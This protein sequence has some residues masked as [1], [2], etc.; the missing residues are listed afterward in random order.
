MWKSFTVLTA[1]ILAVIFIIIVFSGNERV[2]TDAVNKFNSILEKNITIRVLEND[3]AIEQGYLAELMKAFNKKYK[4]YGITVVD[5]NMDQYLD[6]EKDGPYGYGP[7]ILYQANDMLMKYVE[8]KHILPLPIEELDCYNYISEKAWNAYKTTYDNID[9]YF[10]TPTNIQSSLLYYRK[11]LLPENWKTEW[12]DNNNEIPDMVESWTEL[13]KYSKQ[14]I[15]D[16][17]RTKYGY[18]KSLFDVYFSAGYLFSYG[19]YIFGNNSSDC[20]DIGFSKGE[21]EKGGY[22][23]RQLASLMN[24]ECIDDTITRN[25]YSKMAQGIYFAT[26]TTPDVYGLFIKEMVIQYQNQ[27]YT[28]D[29]ATTLAKEN[30]IAIDIPVLPVSGDL[31]DSSS[32]FISCKMMGGIQGYSISSYTEAPNACLAFINF[33]TSYEMMM[34]RNNLLGIVPARTDAATA[35]GGLAKIINNNLEN[36]NIVVMPSIREVAQIWKP[37]ETFFADIAKDPFRKESEIKYTSLDII[38]QGLENVDK[39]I[40]DAIFTLG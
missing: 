22:V 3:T 34:K 4:D 36:G 14:V 1:H 9:Y 6:L 7:D 38:K 23:L 31:E 37:T 27:G 12:D 19:G 32:D 30:L 39:Q 29:D 26:M 33:A 10:G 28:K 5:A 13:Y 11:D 35:I 24:E 2:Q 17:N 8:G 20:S 16:S 15:T 21:A 18:M 40:Y 25:S